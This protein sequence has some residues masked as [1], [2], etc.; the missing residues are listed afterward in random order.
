[1][2]AQHLTMDG[3]FDGI[4]EKPIWDN[5]E[6]AIRRL[7]GKKNTEVIFGPGGE[8]R[9]MLVSGGNNG[10]Y[11]AIITY[12]NETFHNIIDP[13]KADDALVNLVCGGQAADFS[14]RQVNS[15]EP[16]LKAANSYAVAGEV[17]KSLDWSKNY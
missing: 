8:D 1:M 15:L 9:Y 3:D 12:D 11:I 6:Q 10:Q 17:D 13:S 4:I 7:D 14:A 5:I 16:V 2:Y